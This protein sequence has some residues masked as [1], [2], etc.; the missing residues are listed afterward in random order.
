M[1][2]EHAAEVGG[3]G[4]AAGG[5]D[6]RNVP[7]GGGQQFFGQFHALVC[8]VPHRRQTAMLLEHVRQV[9]FADVQPLAG[10]G[11]TAGFEEVR[12][13]EFLRRVV[14]AALAGQAVEFGIGEAERVQQYELQQ[15]LG[16]R[17]PV[18]ARL[19]PFPHE[20]AEQMAHR[21]SVF[22]RRHDAEPLVPEDIAFGGRVRVHRQRVERYRI[23]GKER[24]V[25][26]VAVQYDEVAVSERKRVLV[27]QQPAGALPKKIQFGILVPVR[28]FPVSRFVAVSRRDERGTEPAERRRPHGFTALSALA[29][30]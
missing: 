20:R 16:D 14:Y 7:V 21:L 23:A 28:A 12:V 6:V 17:L 8:D 27:D 4:I 30:W 29:D 11:Q 10:A 3:V 9:E 22:A 24:V 5:G 1:P 15:P 25:P 19:F 13:E 2:F 26:Y 18:V